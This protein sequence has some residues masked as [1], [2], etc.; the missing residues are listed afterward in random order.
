MNF[1]LI[2]LHFEIKNG[3]LTLAL[4]ATG[5][6]DGG[7]CFQAPLMLCKSEQDSWVGQQFSYDVLASRDGKICYS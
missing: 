4:A 2:S 3:H 1:C 7:G 5:Q 6:N